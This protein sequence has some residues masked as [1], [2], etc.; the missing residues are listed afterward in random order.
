[1]RACNHAARQSQADV[2]VFLNPDTVPHPGWLDALVKGLQH[3]DLATAKLLHLSDP[4]RI[5]AFGND[6]HISGIPTC[7]AWGEPATNRADVEEVA[8]VSGACFALRRSVFEELGGFDERLFLYYEDDDLSLRARLAGFRCVAVPQ[9]I[10]LHDHRP[11]LSPAK[12]HYLERNRLWSALKVYRS[13]TLLSLVPALF[14]AEVLTWG[15]ALWLGPEHVRAKLAAWGDLLTWLRR[16]PAERRKTCRRIS[17]RRVLSLHNYRVATAQM[18]DGRLARAAGALATL[19][20]V[21]P[22]MLAWTFADA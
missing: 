21:G 13:R 5:D 22:S 20:F 4:S 1:M 11:G 6:L 18:A 16:L 3:G 15:V 12:L 2:L 14:A 10:V 9:A 19:G 8:A 17:D 7:R